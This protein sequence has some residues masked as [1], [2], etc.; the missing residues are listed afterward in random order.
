[1][2]FSFRFKFKKHINLLELE[3]VLAL[4]RRLACDGVRDARILILVDSRVALGA[5]AKGRSS[6]RRI[7][8]VLK[9]TCAV[10]FAYG[11]YPELIWIPTWA[12]PGDAPSRFKSLRSWR[13]DLPLLPEPVAV[14]LAD[15]TALHERALLRAPLSQAAEELRTSIDAQFPPAVRSEARG[16]TRD[17]W[18]GEL[19]YRA[20]DVERHPG[21]SYQRTTRARFRGARAE[22]GALDV[23]ALDVTQPTV[24]SYEL[25]MQRFEAWLRVRDVRGLDA[26][27]ELGMETLTQHTV[28]YLRQAFADGMLSAAQVGHLLSGIKRFVMLAVAL[29]APVGD[30]PV[31]F[32]TLW[33]VHR[34]WQLAIPP[35]FRAPVSFRTVLAMAIT[36]WLHHSPDLALIVLI[37][38]HCLLRPSEY[39]A[40]RWTDVLIYA[41]DEAARY[42]GTFGI[43]RIEDPKTRRVIG[44]AAHQHVLIECPG[45]ANLFVAARASVPEGGR[46]QPIW[47]GSDADLFRVFSWVSRLLGITALHHTPGCLRGGGATDYWLQTR[48]VP[49]LRRRGRWNNPRTLERYVQEG[50]AEVQQQQLSPDA[51]ERIEALARIAPQF[52]AEAASIL[53]PAGQSPPSSPPPPR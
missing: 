47:S 45:L 15:E 17:A 23:L 38:W 53:R 36:L 29:G 7:N 25:A 16:R 35:E 31:H 13:Q 46:S 28:T 48:D 39:R 24:R 41:P 34:A 6:S 42:P 14:T 4:L 1:M 33:K 50:A 40:L 10:C 11:L 44:H 20:G 37:G 5:L 2:V 32:R 51:R 27:L 22:G 3:A 8:F 18:R 19:I 52:F 49:A 9:K 12:N 43:V 21:P 30:D 26:A